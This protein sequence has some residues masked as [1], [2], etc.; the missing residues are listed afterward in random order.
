MERDFSPANLAESTLASLCKLKVTC[1]Q[2]KFPSPS[3]RP[4]LGALWP[5]FSVPWN[6][7]D[8]CYRTLSSSQIPPEPGTQR[9]KDPQ[10]RL[11]VLGSSGGFLQSMT[12]SW[13]RG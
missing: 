10:H 8:P 4:L 9:P 6:C 3:G 12:V 1:N 5:S 2:T 11:P 7:H 13:L